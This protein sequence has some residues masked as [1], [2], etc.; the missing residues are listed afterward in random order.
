MLETRVGG[1]SSSRTHT[2]RWGGE[3][4]IR[5]RAGQGAVRAVELRQE[6]DERP[7]LHA[8]VVEEETLSAIRPTT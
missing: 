7:V 2:V 3:S 1:Y 4:M 6:R 8:G 5:P